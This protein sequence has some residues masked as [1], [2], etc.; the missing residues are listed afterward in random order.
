M[1]SLTCTL[2]FS[3]TPEIKEYLF[4]FTLWGM[5]PFG[6]IPNNYQTHTVLTEFFVFLHL[7]FPDPQ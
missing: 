7:Y 3:G 6:V 1:P 4:L 2:P 5:S